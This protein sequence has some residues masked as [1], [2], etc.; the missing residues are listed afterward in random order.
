MILFEKK[1]QLFLSA[2]ISK[3]TFQDCGLFFEKMPVKFYLNDINKKGQQSVS[4]FTFWLF[5]L[6]R[7][8]KYGAINILNVELA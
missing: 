2:L 5:F 3:S 7:M 4:F 1:K 8:M 6:L